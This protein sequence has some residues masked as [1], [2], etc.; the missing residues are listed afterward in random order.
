MPEQVYRAPVKAD[1]AHT[2]LFG[3]VRR[4]LAEK[5]YYVVLHVP[6]GRHVDLYGIE[7]IVEVLAELALGDGVPEVHVGGGD[8]PDVGLAD[9]GRADTGELARLQHPQQ[10][11]LVRERQF[12]YLVQKQGSAVSLLEVALAV[13]N[14]SGEGT[15]LVPEEFAFYG[16]LRYSPAID[17]KVFSRPPEAV[18]MYDFRYV[19]LAD[20]A[21]TDDKHGQVCRRHGNSGF[22]G[23]VQRSVV[24]DYVE[25]VLQSYQ[26]LC[27]HQGKV[28]K[29]SLSSLE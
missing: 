1:F 10:F 12:A 8:Y 18:L 15:F 29:K 20:S 28:K 16:P 22:Q 5:Q 2:V 6:Q 19:L 27:F 14:G 7:P 9:L 13:S 17:G 3:I 24:S 23:P 25:L 26:I 21:F 11:G 4:E